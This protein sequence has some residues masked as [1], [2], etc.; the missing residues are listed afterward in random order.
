MGSLGF[1]PM[2]EESAPCVS[3]WNAS[4]R[5]PY[6][7][8]KMPGLLDGMSKATYEEQL[9]IPGAIDFTKCGSFAYEFTAGGAKKYR[10][11]PYALLREARI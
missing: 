1:E 10:T 6:L 3:F 11:Y 2:E 8:R 9:R 7:H 5:P 4:S